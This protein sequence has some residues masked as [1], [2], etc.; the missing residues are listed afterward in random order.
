M[1]TW[2]VPLRRLLLRRRSVRGL[3]VPRNTR[4]ASLKCRLSALI[5]SGRQMNSA[6]F[7]ASLQREASE[8]SSGYL[9]FATCRATT[10]TCADER[11]DAPDAAEGSTPS[12][13]AAQLPKHERQLH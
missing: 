3:S 1:R 4:S 11:C 7:F 13:K 5:A 6:A 8:R 9:S 2:P 10:A 12:D